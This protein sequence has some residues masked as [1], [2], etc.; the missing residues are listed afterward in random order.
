[1]AD[2]RLS[3]VW[4]KINSLG[5]LNA[6][7]ILG[8]PG[9]R[10]IDCAQGRLFCF[11]AKARWIDIW[12]SVASGAGACITVSVL[13]Q[14]GW[15][16]GIVENHM[17][18]VDISESERGPSWRYHRFPTWAGSSRWK[19]APVCWRQALT[20]CV[21]VCVC[22][23]VFVC[24]CVLIRVR[25][26]SITDIA[27]SPASTLSIHIDSCSATGYS[28]FICMAQPTR[29]S[30][31]IIFPLANLSALISIILCLLRA[32]TAPLSK[33]KKRP[34]LTPSQSL[35]SQNLHSNM[36]HTQTCIC[37]FE[38]CSDAPWCRVIVFYW[39]WGKFWNLS[40]FY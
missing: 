24:L 7:G 2:A 12:W 40:F 10:T 5:F 23:F 37:L 6:A 14:W 8:R 26:C 9:R 33:E 28:L 18:P 1:M 15:V 25:L 30:V 38:H 11:G 16:P 31:A 4:S 35:N 27:L 32:L 13:C 22:V 20:L 19:L 17:L 34:P 29:Q 36:R 3:G 39:Q 21:C